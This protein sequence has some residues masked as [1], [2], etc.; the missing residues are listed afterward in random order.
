MDYETKLASFFR[1]TVTVKIP[2]ILESFADIRTNPRIHLRDILTSVFLLPMIG[3]TGFATIGLSPAHK[4]MLS[5][6]RCSQILDLLKRRDLL[7]SVGADL[8]T[9]S[10]PDQVDPMPPDLK[11][12][13]LDLDLGT[14]KKLPRL[15]SHPRG[16]EGDTR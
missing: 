9:L 3:L 11:S 2:Q 12:I 6:F 16:S 7:L 1:D 10:L 5:L 14:R 8:F 13:H 4:K 15:G